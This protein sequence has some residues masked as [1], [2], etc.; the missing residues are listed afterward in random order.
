MAYHTGSPYSLY[1]VMDVNRPFS[2]FGESSYVSEPYH[3]PHAPVIS[4]MFHGSYPSY[5]EE[6]GD[7]DD[8]CYYNEDD[9]YYYNDHDDYY[10]N[11]EDFPME[12]SEISGH[13]KSD[14]NKTGGIQNKTENVENKTG[15]VENKTGKVENKTG[16][17]ENKTGKVENKTGKVENKTG[18]VENKTGK[19]ENKTGKVENKTG[20]VENKSEG[21]E[22]TN[23]MLTLFQAVMIIVH[24][25][26]LARRNST[27]LM[28]KHEAR[29]ELLKRLDEINRKIKEDDLNMQ[30]RL[31]EL[32]KEIKDEE[33]KMEMKW[34][35]KRAEAR[36]ELALMRSKDKLPGVGP[37]YDKDKRLLD[38]T[39]DAINMDYEKYKLK[40]KK[41]WNSMRAR[42][43]KDL[44][45]LQFRQQQRKLQRCIAMFFFEEKWNFG[46]KEL[47][48]Y[49]MLR[50]RR[51]I[52][53]EAYHRKKILQE[54][55]KERIKAM[56]EAER[57][58]AARKA[59]AAA[60]EELERKVEEAIAIMAAR[61]EERR[62]NQQDQYYYFEKLGGND[63][64]EDFDDYY[65]H[66]P[67]V[68]GYE[69]EDDYHS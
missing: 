30:K 49:M 43:H 60:A 7:D 24:L 47:Q 10:Y 20:K 27:R 45:R 8:G 52:L 56:I 50:L 2:S 29:K 66:H 33:E 17:V 1:S 14:E 28:K 34:E 22:N 42:Y 54:K 46:P 38:R 16:K 21:V 55:E 40:K 51:N 35:G 53:D 64:Y 13:L 19:V 41:R 62:K 31:E 3:P 12:E 61:E 44:A 63:Y 39:L 36:N 5:Y 68:H 48:K 6:D 59:E 11:E 69:D 23:N 58:E 15:K 57:A 37:V 25:M 4:N 67:Y 26:R 18:K 65:D 9:G 32:K